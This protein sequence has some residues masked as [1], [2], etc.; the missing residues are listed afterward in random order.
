M[1]T[2]LIV[3]MR[4]CYQTLTWESADIMTSSQSLSSITLT[5]GW[6]FKQTDNVAEDAWLSVERVPTNIHLD[7]I[8][9][10]KYV[11]KNHEIHNT[12]RN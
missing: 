12:A 3:G 7:L 1:N 10:G 11:S 8:E 2:P 6:Q 9:H 5:E 4:S